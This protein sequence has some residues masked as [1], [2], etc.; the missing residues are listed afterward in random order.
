MVFRRGAPITT[1]KH[2]V[3]S[4]GAITSTVSINTIAFT[5]NVRADPFNPVDV[6]TGSKVSSFFI[7]LFIIGSTGAPVVGAQNW[8]INKRH[9][10]QQTAFPDP[11]S[12]GI[13]SVRNQIFHEE[14]GL[15]GSGDGTAMVFKG[16]IKVPKSMQRMREGDAF[17]V[18]ILNN[19]VDSAQFCLKAIYKEWT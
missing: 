7:S 2:V 10:G 11:G 15:T 14:K 9:D 18:R 3:D 4:E 13:S 19:G 1:I 17:D 5:R 16:V 12:T 8:Y 6:I